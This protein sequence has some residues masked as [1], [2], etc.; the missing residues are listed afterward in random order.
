[1]SD[2]VTDLLVNNTRDLQLVTYHVKPVFRNA[3]GH[4]QHCDR[5]I[6]TTLTI[7]LNPT[8]VLDSVYVSDTV[9]CNQ[10]T[11]TF[12]IYNSQS[13]TGVVVYGLTTDYSSA[14]IAGVRA[15]D[16]QYMINPQGFTDSLINSS[17]VIQP[18]T[19]HFMP[20]IIDPGRGLLCDRGVSESTIV[21]V[22]PTLS[23]TA[24]IAGIHRRTSDKVL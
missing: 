5:G 19:Y 22:V 12:R 18:V 17:H 7:Y 1:M 4:E 3:D 23:D 15:E 21:K 11:I 20:K 2:P 6:D 10:T 14:D 16:S 24:F 13:T 8:P 9:I